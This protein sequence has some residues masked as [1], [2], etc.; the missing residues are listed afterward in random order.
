MISGTD[1]NAVECCLEVRGDQIWEEI[2][3]SKGQKV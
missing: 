2:P 1:E 3:T